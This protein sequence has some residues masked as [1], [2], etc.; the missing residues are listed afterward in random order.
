MDAPNRIT[1]FKGALDFLAGPPDQEKLSKTRF[2]I[3]R[4]ALT[5][6]NLVFAAHLK[7]Y[8]ELSEE[9]KPL[10]A[11]IKSIDLGLRPEGII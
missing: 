1:E 9:T 6:F 5:E 8:N 2:I 7:K 11:D 4:H 10:R 3:I